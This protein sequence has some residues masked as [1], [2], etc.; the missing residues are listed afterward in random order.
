MGSSPYRLDELGWLQFDRLCSLLLE[1]EAGLSDLRWRGR[2]DAARLALVDRQVALRGRPD[3]LARPVTVAAVWVRHGN[4]PERR[5][6]EF[7]DHVSGARAEFETWS[8]G[9]LFVLTN[10]ERGEAVA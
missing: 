3:G 7:T 6:A 4:V 5:L 8:E 10:L 1:A 9:D 2:G